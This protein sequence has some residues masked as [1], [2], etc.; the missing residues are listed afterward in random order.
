MNSELNFQHFEHED[1]QAVVS[2]DNGTTF[3]LNMLMENVNS[4]FKNS[5]L[6]GLSEKLK[7]A[8]LGYPPNNYINSWNS[9]GVKAE[10]LE[11]KSE[12]WKKGKVRMRVILEFCP[13]EPKL[14]GDN[15]QNNGN[16]SDGICQSIS[17]D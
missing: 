7:Q 13:D 15:V 17:L 11:P 14:N 8:G 6:N 9:S 4:F 3:K 1:S 12:E 10:I 5:V 16:S 2:F